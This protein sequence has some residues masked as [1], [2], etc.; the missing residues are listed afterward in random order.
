MAAF[1]QYPK[2]WNRTVFELSKNLLVLTTFNFFNSLGRTPKRK[3][4]MS[5]NDC[6]TPTAGAM[7][8][9]SLSSISN[10]SGNDTSFKLTMACIRCWSFMH[11]NN[12]FVS[13]HFLIFR[14]FPWLS[15]TKF[16]IWFTFPG[17]FEVSAIFVSTPGNR[18]QFLPTFYQINIVSL[19]CSGR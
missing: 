6:P 1:D 17:D 9:R 7:F 5:G 11:A 2:P 10:E 19:V 8:Q 18:D 4:S 12:M 3:L 14:L 16:C 15:D 13:L